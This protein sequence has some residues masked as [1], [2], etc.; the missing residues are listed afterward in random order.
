MSTSPSDSSDFEEEEDKLKKYKYIKK[1]GVGITGR[2]DLYQHLE[3]KKQFAIKIMSLPK[4]RFKYD[5]FIEKQIQA[6]ILALN[7]LKGNE[8]IIEL[9]EVIERT[10]SNSSEICLVLEYCNDGDLVD[11]IGEDKLDEKLGKKYFKQLVLGVSFIHENGFC[12]RDLKPENLLFS[13]GVLKI[14]DFGWCSEIK[15]NKLLNMIAGTPSYCAPEV[16]MGKSYDGK[17]AD[18]WSMGICLYT[19]LTGCFAF[20]NESIDQLIQDMI[21][22]KYP[23]PIFLSKDAQDLIKKILVVDPNQRISLDEIKKHSWM[24]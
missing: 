6:E 8:H 1:L 12:H 9:H 10:T 18:I 22:L 14:S 7:K 15:K 19:M 24:K 11:Q 13:N 20:D 23:P 3:T 21:K 4:D 5:D 17:K 16:L 2:I